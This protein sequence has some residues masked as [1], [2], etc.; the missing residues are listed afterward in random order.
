[1]SKRH[2]PDTA[3][4]EP[5]KSP[6]KHRRIEEPLAPLTI[7]VGR[8]ISG[9]VPLAGSPAAVV[10]SEAAFVQDILQGSAQITMY[11]GTGGNGGGG[12]G[13]GVGG[14]GEGP[15]LIEHFSGQVIVNYAGTGGQLEPGCQVN[16]GI[17]RIVAG[18][19]NIRDGVVEVCAQLQDFVKDWWLRQL[20]RTRA[21][22]S[23]IPRG[24][25]DHLIWVIDPVGLGIPVPTEY[26]PDI[27]TLHD[28]LDVYMRQRPGYR[29]MMLHSDYRLVAEDGNF[30]S[31]KPE[32]KPGVV[33]EIS[34][35]E[36]IQRYTTYTNQCPSCD[37]TEVIVPDVAWE[38]YKCG[39]V[40]CAK[41]FKSCGVPI[42]ERHQ[43]DKAVV[44]S[45]LN[46]GPAQSE[47]ESMPKRQS[48]IS[49]PDW[50]HENGIV[51]PQLAQA[52]HVEKQAFRLVHILVE[53]RH[54]F[55]YGK[56]V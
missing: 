39:N 45:R 38:W 50:P 46:Q 41:R 7:G 32:L 26:C 17:G 29:E 42:P 28:I 14:V 10:A 11:G 2:F 40:I 23:H 22:N 12:A 18:V 30:L 1:M 51:S 53:A 31:F 37:S 44:E 8:T 20:R 13:G 9:R 55:E 16:P 25:Y 34:I 35:C 5:D 47:L 27:S 24:V 43:W 36:N 21:V 19:A 56:R 3:Y 54:H 15:R 52:D 33:L 48:L 6:S 4:E 49:S